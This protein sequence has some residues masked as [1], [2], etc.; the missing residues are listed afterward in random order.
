MCMASQFVA[1]EVVTFVARVCVFRFQ[2]PF[3]K[4]DQSVHEFENGA[5]RVWRLYCSVEHR[6]VRV[7]YYFSIVFTDI[8]KHFHVD[9][10]AGN[11][12]K[13]LAGGRFYRHE[14]AYLILHQKLSILL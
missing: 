11:H 2:D 13:N 8:G 4:S 5:W 10:R 1:A 3:L 9:S 7:A 6:L 14:T 12:G